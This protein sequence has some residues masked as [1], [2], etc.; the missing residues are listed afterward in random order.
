MFLYQKLRKNLKMVKD[1]DFEYE[2]DDIDYLE[3]MQ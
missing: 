2:E 1:N 3:G